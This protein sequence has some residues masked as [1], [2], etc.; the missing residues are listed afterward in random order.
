MQYN[1]ADRNV[2]GSYFNK[3]GQKIIMT[4]QEILK[5]LGASDFKIETDFLYYTFNG[6]T[7]CLNLKNLM[8]DIFCNDNSVD[9]NLTSPEKACEKT[10]TV[11]SK[12]L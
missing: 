2:I 7:R 5:D 8:M 4:L 9:H 12:S 10:L 11:I 3:Y 6:Q 1:Q